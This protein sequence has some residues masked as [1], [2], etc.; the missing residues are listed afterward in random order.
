[1]FFKKR[2]IEFQSIIN[3]QNFNKYYSIKKYPEASSFITLLNKK[4]NDEEIINDSRRLIKFLSSPLS[5][6]REKQ[7]NHYKKVTIENTADFMI[8]DYPK[9]FPDVIFVPGNN[10][11]SQLDD[12]I[13]NL[14]LLKKKLIENHIEHVDEKIASIPIVISGKGG[15]GVTAGPIFVTTEAEAMHQHLKNRI[16]YVNRE[17]KHTFYLE[18]EA[19]N[20]GANVD[21]TK[22]IMRKIAL[23]KQK[24][25][26]GLNVWLV[27]TPVGGIRQLLTVSK[28]SGETTEKGGKGYILNQV[29]MLPNPDKIIRHYFNLNHQ[30]ELGINFFAALRETMN[31]INY[32]LNNDFISPNAP[33]LNDLRDALSIAFKYYKRF[34]HNKIINEEES[35]QT[36]INFAALKE[37]KGGIKHLEERDKESIKMTA[38]DINQIIQYFLHAF[39]QIERQYMDYLP[40]K[41]TLKNK[42][43]PSPSLLRQQERLTK[44]YTAFFHSHPFVEDQ[45]SMGSES[46]SFLSLQ[47]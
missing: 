18:K 23:E 12:L 33:D 3:S 32:M 31:Y 37:E 1:M 7:S 8:T 46:V 5:L 11:L 39:A 43:K 47:G 20:S 4:M 6:V 28:Q 34:T 17:L 45:P 25:E 2:L 19:G 42:E 38:E 36:I 13:Y 35:I 41:L 24:E 29:Y 9:N 27:P 10:D 26:Q 21:F 15:H 14:F 16:L 22:S 30:E 44:P 40:E